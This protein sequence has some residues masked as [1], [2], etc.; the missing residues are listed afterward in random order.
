MLIKFVLGL[1]LLA[2]SFVAAAVPMSSADESAF[3]DTA[4]DLR[5]ENDPEEGGG[6]CYQTPDCVSFPTAPTEEKKL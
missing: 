2:T 1:A 5:E 3:G 4:L 6:V